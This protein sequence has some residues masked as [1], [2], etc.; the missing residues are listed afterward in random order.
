MVIQRVVLLRV[1]GSRVLE[2]TEVQ[3]EHVLVRSSAV[4]S[5]EHH[6]VFLILPL[7][8]PRDLLWQLLSKP[9]LL[10]TEE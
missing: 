7:N 6:S 8:V 5:T 3:D 9:R 4:K 1:T 10:C 2:Y